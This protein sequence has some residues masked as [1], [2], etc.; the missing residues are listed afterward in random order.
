[1]SFTF[2]AENSDKYSVLVENYPKWSIPNRIYNEVTVP[3][4][5]G[6]LKFDTG[7]FANVPQPYD[8][9]IIAK[10]GDFET[11]VHEF[12]S[13]LNSASGYLRLEDT[14]SP[15]TYRMGCFT[16]NSAEIENIFNE[17]GR[18]T[19]NFDCKPFRWLKSGETAVTISATNT[20]IT[21][22][23]KFAS[24]PLIKVIGSAAGTITIGNVQM[25]IKTL[26]DYIYIDCEEQNIYRQ[27][28]ENMNSCVALGE[29]C[30]IPSGAS[31]VYFDGGITSLEITPRWCSQ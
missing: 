21:N 18:A 17:L 19:I 25:S 14:H 22:P 1:M 16:G 3:G 11:K 23:T 30:T 24:K 26:A 7:A 10:D 20:Q 2:N 9:A 5:S 28:S 13:W 15:D 27:T 6:T 29:F 31:S 8:V 12:I 4:R